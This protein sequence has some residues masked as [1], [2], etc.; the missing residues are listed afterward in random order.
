LKINKTIP[1]KAKTF[2]F[3]SYNKLIVSANPDS[4][5]DIDSVF[6]ENPLV[7]PSLKSIPPIINLK[8]L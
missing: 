7:R 4:I 8:R 5:K 1:N 6:I 2:E 3:K